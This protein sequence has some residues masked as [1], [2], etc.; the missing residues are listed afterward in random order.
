MQI[1]TPGYWYI[2]NKGFCGVNLR[3]PLNNR[4]EFIAETGNPYVEYIL[5]S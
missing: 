4:Y 5:V 1:I 2:K 3:K